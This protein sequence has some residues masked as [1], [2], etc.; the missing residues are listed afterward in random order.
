MK[1]LS[2]VEVLTSLPTRKEVMEEDYTLMDVVSF[3]S[4]ESWSL[5][6][7]SSQFMML[8]LSLQR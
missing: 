6:D 8:K 3:V 7:P 1:Y 5:K 4:T 2:G